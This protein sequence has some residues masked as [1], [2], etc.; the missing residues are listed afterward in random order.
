MIMAFSVCEVRPAELARAVLCLDELSKDVEGE[1]ILVDA[2]REVCRT[3]DCVTLTSEHVIRA[4]VRSHACDSEIGRLF[5]GRLSVKDLT[6]VFAHGT[7]LARGLHVGTFVW[8]TSAGVVQGRLSGMTN[9]GTH[10][11]PAFKGCQECGERGVMEGKLCGRLVRASD[12]KLAGAQ[13]TAAYRFAFEP[14]EKGG[15]GTLR[16]TVEGV[17]V[18][19]CEPVAECVSFGTVGVDANPRV[20]GPVTIETR[21]STGTG[22]AQTEV[23]TWGGQTGLHLWHRSRVSFAAP[24]SRVELTLVHFSTA[25]TATAFD[26][27]GIPVA[28]ATVSVGQQTPETLVL[29]GAGIVTVEVDAPSDEVLLTRLCWA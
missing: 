10:R 3:L 17:V 8:R 23:V 12:P 29:T 21:D 25:P 19:T 6:T 13:V 14:N 9:E 11:E 7:G 27:T 1:L 4:E 5:D 16:G 2:D 26:A 18:R 20:L 24:V 15:G 28:T 22:P